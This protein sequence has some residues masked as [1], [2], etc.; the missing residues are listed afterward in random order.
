MTV[1]RMI[2]DMGVCSHVCKGG[3]T[4]EQRVTWV[5]ECERRSVAS[6]FAIMYTLLV[7]VERH[8]RIQF[9]YVGVLYI[10]YYNI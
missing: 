5:R 4:R 6:M 1:L 3:Y 9:L 2:R 10:G 8:D 7:E